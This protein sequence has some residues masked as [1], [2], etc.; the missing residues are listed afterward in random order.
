MYQH[1]NLGKLIGRY[2]DN[3]GRETDYYKEIKN[4]IQLA[5]EEKQAQTT[6]SIKYPPCNIEWSPEHGSRVW[7]TKRRF[8]K[9]CLLHIKY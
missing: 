9:S 7:C 4:M 5:E 6:E 1:A 8:V 2:Y 3:F